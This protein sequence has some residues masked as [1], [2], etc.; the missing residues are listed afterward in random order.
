MI[1]LITDRTQEHVDH[2]NT[3]RG[4]GWARMTSAE[5][6]EWYEYA[7]KGAYNYT[8]LNRVEAAVAELAAMLGIELTTKT[9]WTMWD[10]PTQADMTRYL[11]NVERLR[12]AVW[13]G[14]SLPD[15]PRRMDNLTYVDANNIETILLETRKRFES[16]PQCG[17][18]YSGE[19]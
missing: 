17:E 16:A 18:I 9:N 14:V 10:I 8:D 12:N 1:E 6:D 15:V 5:R 3:L 11:S 4:I 13:N 19:V 2:L 7:A